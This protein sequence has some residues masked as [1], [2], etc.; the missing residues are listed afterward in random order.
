MAVTFLSEA[1]KLLTDA[2]KDRLCALRAITA[3]RM[4]NSPAGG[5]SGSGSEG[6]SVAVANGEVEGMLRKLQ[7][8]LASEITSSMAVVGEE[9]VKAAA[10]SVSSAEV[11]AVVREFFWAL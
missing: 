5:D 9:E 6:G 10:A 2:S 7:S 11:N 4:T 1:I 8:V 3:E